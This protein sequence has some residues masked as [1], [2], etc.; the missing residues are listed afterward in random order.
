M[1]IRYLQKGEGVI[2]TF[3]GEIILFYSS[4]LFNHPNGLS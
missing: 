4:L 3:A 1:I 2:V